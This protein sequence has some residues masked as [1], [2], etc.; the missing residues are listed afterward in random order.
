LTPIRRWALQRTTQLPGC[1]HRRDAGGLHRRLNS[2]G[3]G[4]RAAA[5]RDRH[6]AQRGRAS[7][8]NAVPGTPSQTRGPRF[9]WRQGSAGAATRRSKGGDHAGPGLRSRPSSGTGTDADADADAEAEAEA[10][11]EEKTPRL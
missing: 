4:R 7:Q 11:A 2:R 3:S 6:C 8:L 5:A 1:I 9:W 10:E